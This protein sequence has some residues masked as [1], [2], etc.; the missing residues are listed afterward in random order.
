MWHYLC[1]QIYP[2][3]AI[4]MGGG[5]NSEK[6]KNLDQFLSPGL[7]QFLTLETPNLGPAFNSTARGLKAPNFQ[8]KPVENPSWEMG[9]FMT[10]KWGFGVAMLPV[11]A[12]CF[13]TVAI[14]GA[15]CFQN[16]HCGPVSSARVA[17]ASLP[18][19][20][21]PKSQMW[22][23]AHLGFSDDLWPT[24]AL[25]FLSFFGGN[26]CEEFLFSLFPGIRGSR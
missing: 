11:G 23:L 2:K 4:K 22:P 18:P 8:R 9:P 6:K 3:N 14:L 5:G 25:S 7:D 13:Y 10:P 1:F 24:Q 21:A 26:S 17:E 12:W 19:S 15:R 16:G 20:I